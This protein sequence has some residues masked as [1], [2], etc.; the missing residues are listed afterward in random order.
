MTKKSAR[1]DCSDLLKALDGRVI[2]MVGMMGCGKSAVGRRLAARLGLP[3]VDADDEIQKAAGMKIS[4]IFADQGEE[5]FR[6]RERLVIDRLLSQ[7]RQVLATGGGAFMNEKTR[8]RVREVGISVWL[9]ADFDILMRRVGR[10]GDK[11]PLLQGGNREKIMRDLL[12]ERSPIYAKADIAVE[13]R[14]GPHDEVVGEIIQQ[15]KSKLTN[16]SK[17]S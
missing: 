1:S 4:E 11:R 3:F 7:G 9:K 8:A 14:D 6:D 16:M 2:V 12:E 17:I 13:S 10:R 5:F 15:L